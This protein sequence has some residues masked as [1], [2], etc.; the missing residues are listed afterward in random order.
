MRKED[1]D[2]N[3]AGFQSMLMLKILG[4]RSRYYSYHNIKNHAINLKKNHFCT[5]CISV[6][7]HVVFVIEQ[8]RKWKLVL[9]TAI[10]LAV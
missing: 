7:G 1:S 8:G 3:F 2:T 5:T 6:L 10:E 9:V 4:Y